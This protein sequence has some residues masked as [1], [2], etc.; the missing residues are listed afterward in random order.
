MRGCSC[1]QGPIG[2]S[3]LR[4]P[5]LTA[6]HLELMPKHQQLNVFHVQTPA[7]TNQ[8]AKQSRTAM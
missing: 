3:K 8:R 1:E 2:K 5:N 6:Q 4:S 7:A